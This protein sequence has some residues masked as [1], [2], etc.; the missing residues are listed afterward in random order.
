M[1]EGSHIDPNI[2]L[3]KVQS[4]DGSTYLEIN[5]PEPVDQE[6]SDLENASI[7]KMRKQMQEIN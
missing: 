3:K 2:F 6:E 7:K 5:T 1:I 4:E